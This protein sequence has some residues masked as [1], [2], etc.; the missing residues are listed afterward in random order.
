MVEIGVLKQVEPRSTY[1]TYPILQPSSTKHPVDFPKE[2]DT[3][4]VLMKP[5]AMIARVQANHICGRYRSVALTDNPVT[6]AAG[7]IDAN[8]SV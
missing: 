3:R 1:K 5:R 4:S 7:A 6:I 2:S 8:A